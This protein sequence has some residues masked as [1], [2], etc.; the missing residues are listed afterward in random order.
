MLVLL[1]RTTW[2]PCAALTYMFCYYLHVGI[3]RTEIQH[4]DM[5]TERAVGLWKSWLTLSLSLSVCVCV[6]WDPSSLHLPPTP[7]FFLDFFY[8][9]SLQ[10]IIFCLV[11]LCVF[12]LIFQLSQFLAWD[13]VNTERARTWCKLSQEVQNGSYFVLIW[14]VERLDGWQVKQA[15]RVGNQAYITRAY[16]EN[17]AGEQIG[18]M[19]H[20]LNH[21]WHKG[22]AKSVLTRSHV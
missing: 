6:L 9:C 13:L 22:Q 3:T 15:R 20:N 16:F 8:S 17:V 14:C 19:M 18:L 11:T 5:M 4:F 10:F 2:R 1:F 7:P 21:P 12:F